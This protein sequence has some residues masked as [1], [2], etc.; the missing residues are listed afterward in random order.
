MNRY[1][2]TEFRDRLPEAMDLADKGKEVIVERYRKGQN[3]L[4]PKS[5]PKLYVLKQKDGQ[6]AE[7]SS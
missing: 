2:A 6:Q 7:K 3:K 5:I 1:T 4:N